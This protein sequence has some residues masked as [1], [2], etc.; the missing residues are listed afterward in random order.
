MNA[1]LNLSEMLVSRLSRC[2]K[3]ACILWLAFASFSGAGAQEIAGDANNVPPAVPASQSASQENRAD[4]VSPTL[5]AVPPSPQNMESRIVLPQGN[6]N[7]LAALDQS[8][9]SH[10]AVAPS[11][12]RPDELRSLF[13][14]TWQYALLQEAKETIRTRPPGPGE[15]A[16]GEQRPA[17]P[18][19]ISLGGISYL[20]KDSWT[21]WLNSQ[22]VK[23]D[24]IPK[25]IFD[26]KVSED[27]IDIKWYDTSTNLIY[28]IRLRPHQRFNLDNRIFL[29]GTGT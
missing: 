6:E 14:T 1:L 12:V 19:E 28:P 29:P 2:V 7:S 9:K 26:I 25:E 15:G 11:S 8:L 13:F 23:P 18:R 5:S 22:R 21:V 20:N 16:S 17:G 3:A 24:A 27:H 4:A 10:L